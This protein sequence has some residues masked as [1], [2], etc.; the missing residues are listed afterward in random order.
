MGTIAAPSAPGTVERASALARLLRAPALGIALLGAAT[1]PAPTPS[2][3]ASS[4]ATHL[5]GAEVVARVLERNAAAPGYRA[6]IH[7]RARLLGFPFASQRLDGEVSFS[8]PDSHEI[9]FERVPRY[10]RSF[11]H[12]FQDAADPAFWA[13]DQIVTVDGDAPADAIALRVT[14]KTP[15]SR[16]DHI[17]VLVDPASYAVRSI[18]WDYTNGGKILMTQTY[19]SLD[20]VSVPAGQ[21][22]SIVIPHVRAE[23]DA[24]YDDYRVVEPAAR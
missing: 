22:A 7:V 17:T 8:P 16:V 5:D 2:A 24:T 19:R 4:P 14:R 21:H 10:A 20:G 15:G 9:V 18:E 12:V 1:P 11:A 6:R 13:K 23:A 3:G